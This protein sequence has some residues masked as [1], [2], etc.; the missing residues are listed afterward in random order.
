MIFLQNLRSIVNFG[1]SYRLNFFKFH[2]S[3][4]TGGNGSYWIIFLLEHG[5]LC[6]KS[7][8]TNNLLGG[9]FVG[10]F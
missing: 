6:I 3:A 7:L 5:C 10:R 4:P 8:Y 1:P 9:F 2:V